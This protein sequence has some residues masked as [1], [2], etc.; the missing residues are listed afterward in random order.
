MVDDPGA[1]DEGG[2][3]DADVAETVAAV[4]LG[5]D[6]EQGMCV[7]SDGGKRVRPF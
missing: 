4:L 6:R 3:T 1:S 5:T 2:D 7:E